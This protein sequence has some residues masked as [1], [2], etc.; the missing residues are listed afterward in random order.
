M[1][2][3]QLGPGL[4]LRFIVWPLLEQLSKPAPSLH[5]VHA[6]VHIAAEVGEGVTQRHYLPALQNLLQRALKQT[7]V[8]DSRQLPPL[9]SLIQG[10]LRVS[11]LCHVSLACVWRVRCPA[12]RVVI[13]P[14]NTN[15]SYPT[16]LV[17]QVLSADTVMQEFVVG[18]GSVHLAAILSLPQVNLL[19]FIP[20]LLFFIIIINLTLRGGTGAGT[21]R[22]MGGE[23]S[24]VP[25]TARG[26]LVLGRHSHWYTHSQNAPRP[27]SYTPLTRVST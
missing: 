24:A 7:A 22:R 6:L 21:S 10:V 3:S 2:S 25:P 23:P 17:D 11:R 4:A 18:G 19:L 20:H 1:S 12:V 5:L 15:H 27:A 26:C 14:V 16:Q 13:Q 9:F 8:G